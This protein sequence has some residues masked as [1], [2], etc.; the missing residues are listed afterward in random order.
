MRAL[1]RWPEIWLCA[2]L[3]T[4]CADDSGADEA[5]SAAPSDSEAAPSPP[6]GD[7]GPPEELPRGDAAIGADGGLDGA[8][9]DGAAEAGSASD[10]AAGERSDAAPSRTPDANLALAD[11]GPLGP[12]TIW[13][14]GD[15]TVARGET[16]CPV[17]W[18][19]S[20]AEHFRSE[21]KIVNSAIGGRSVRTWLYQVTSM[22]GGDGECV[23]MNDARG[24]PILQARWQA[25]LDGMKPGDHLLIQFG[26]NDTSRTCDRHV[27]I[28]AFK[29]SY[30]RM[31]QAATQRGAQPIFITPVSAIACEG[32]VAQE[33]RVEYA[34]ATLEAG[35]T[36]GVPVIDLHR[37]SVALY[38]ERGFC[39]IPGGDVGASTRGAVGDFFCEDHTHFSAQ[40]AAQIAVLVAQAIR[41]QK[42]ALAAYLK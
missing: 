2:W 39:P 17:G 26:I 16:P 19:A 21:V 10:A 35:K 30:G 27:G 32:K 13:I 24:Q 34:A 37:R 1:G 8:S 18:G 20:I 41:E 5:L 29:S 15:S 36:Y 3:L 23:L 40:G 38:N 7:G 33:S 14:A 6:S 11:A 25:M 28:A 42:L 4:G 12:R 9:G 31:A 22:L